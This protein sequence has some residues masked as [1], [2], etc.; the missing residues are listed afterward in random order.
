MSREQQL[1]NE[2]CGLD[3]IPYEFMTA[4]IRSFIYGKETPQER[5][6]RAKAAALE[7]Y[8]DYV[9][10][11]GLVKFN[12]GNR[13]R[14]DRYYDE[15]TFMRDFREFSIDSKYAYEP[16]EVK[17]YFLEPTCHINWNF[18]QMSQ[19]E[20]AQEDLWR[21]YIGDEGYMMEMKTNDDTIY[22]WDLTEDEF[23]DEVNS[24]ITVHPG[25][26]EVPEIEI[27]EL[28]QTLKL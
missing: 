16:P 7:F 12:Q 13:I 4:E 22:S 10:P 18:T 3:A 17:L 9:E 14:I 27:Y 15:T 28:V 1:R 8:S 23:I 2:A 21:C 11:E 5:K 26:I 19:W 6:R 24:H 20:D 25:S